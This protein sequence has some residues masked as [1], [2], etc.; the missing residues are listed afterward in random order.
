MIEVFKTDVQKHSQANKLIALLHE[1]FPNIKINFDLQDC[2]KILRVE[3]VNFMP[4]KVTLLVKENGFI[5]KTL[6]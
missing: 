3:G 1:H 5:C 2:D 4:E 6:E